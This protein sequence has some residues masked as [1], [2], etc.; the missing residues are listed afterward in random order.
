M[1][2]GWWFSQPGDPGRKSLLGFTRDA[3]VTHVNQQL[4]G[5]WY[6]RRRAGA[7]GPLARISSTHFSTIAPNAH[8]R[9]TTVSPTFLVWRE[10]V[11][12]LRWGSGVGFH[13]MLGQQLW[14]GMGSETG[15][16]VCLATHP[17]GLLSCQDRKLSSSR[18][19]GEGREVSADHREGREKQLPFLEG[20]ER[21][22]L[23]P[24][25]AGQVGCLG[26][27]LS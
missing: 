27:W 7:R 23:H 9:I 6:G 19:P 22:R 14:P 18:L 3:E 10:G 24:E 5:D 2:V 8:S 20:A 15:R 25:A 21:A 11:T 1:V 13:V 4:L 12:P 26:S 16:M 17:T